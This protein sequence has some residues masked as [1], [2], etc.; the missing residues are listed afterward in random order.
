LGGI[1]HRS[2]M[3]NPRTAEERS[4]PKTRQLLGLFKKGTEH[5]SAMAQKLDTPWEPD[6]EDPRRLHNS[7]VRNLVA[8]YPSKY[9][10]LSQAILAALDREDYLTYALCGRALIE[11]V[12]TLR[13]YVLHQYRPLLD[14]GHLNTEDFRTLIQI[15]DRH[16]R[17]SRFDWESFFF[18][19]YAKMKEDAV[20]Q[21]KAKGDKSQRKR[22]E[23]SAAITAQ[24]V[25]VLTCIEKW[26]VEM[27][28]ILIAYDL[29]CDLVHPNIGSNFLVSS[30]GSGKLYFSKHKGDTVGQHI[31]EQSFPILVSAT[32]KPF[33]QYLAALMGTC[34][35][36]NEIE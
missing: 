32:Q 15:D 16:L 3:S 17:G 21:L 12:A 8:A 22:A 18:G 7:Y 24:Q 11:A 34:W 36:E 29:F 27:P 4:A 14:K 30:V 6:L 28:E 1:S 9:A 13:Y 31:F 25:N 5:L 35:Q 2:A 10:D 19:R 26:A 33:G 23:I 20:S